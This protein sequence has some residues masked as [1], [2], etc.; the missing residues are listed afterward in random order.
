[1]VEQE[2]R[3]CVLVLVPH[4]QEIHLELTEDLVVVEVLETLEL[5]L[6]EEL[7]IHLQLVRLKVIQEVLDYIPEE[8]MFTVVELVV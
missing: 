6:Q 2:E 7:V 4:N 5:P 8:L 1:V 3:F